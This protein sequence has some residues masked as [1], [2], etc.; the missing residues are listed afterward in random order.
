MI[1]GAKEIDMDGSKDCL[2]HNNEAKGDINFKMDYSKGGSPQKTIL[3][4]RRNVV[5]DGGDFIIGPNTFSFV[6]II[7]CKLHH[8][9]GPKDLML[10]IDQSSYDHA[11]CNG[12]IDGFKE[13]NVNTEYANYSY[14]VANRKRSINQEGQVRPTPI[15]SAPSGLRAKVVLEP[16]KFVRC[17]DKVQK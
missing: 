10:L 9:I 1:K 4:M 14:F 15:Y 5:T 16:E 8:L 7:E 12:G 17:G 13:V 2:F 6:V 11:M 3:T